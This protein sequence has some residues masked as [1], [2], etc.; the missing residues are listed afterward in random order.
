MH[1]YC[2]VYV[3]TSF[4]PLAATRPQECWRRTTLNGFYIPIQVYVPRSDC[5]LL[6]VA[7]SVGQMPQKTRGIHEDGISAEVTTNKGN[8]PVNCNMGHYGT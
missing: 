7:D 3:T 1:S 4:L 2:A 5:S 6:T 8:A